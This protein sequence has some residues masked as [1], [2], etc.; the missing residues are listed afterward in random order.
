MVLH[1]NLLS[2]LIIGTIL[3][4]TGQYKS[5]LASDLLEQQAFWLVAVASGVVGAGLNFC[6]FWCVQANGATTYAVVGALNKIPLV[7]LGILLFN[8]TPS[9]K[10]MVD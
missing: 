7:G 10:T 3:I 2:C 9:A 1:N 4:S 5:I 6:S 8:Y